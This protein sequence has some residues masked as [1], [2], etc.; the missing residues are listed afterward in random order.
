[1]GNVCSPTA[2]PAGISLRS[3]ERQLSWVAGG[4]DSGSRSNSLGSSSHVNLYE[5]AEAGD[6][7]I[8]YTPST[9]DYFN[10][11][12]MCQ[13]MPSKVVET[14][15]IPEKPFKCVVAVV[16]HG[17]RLDQVDPAAW[18]RSD[19]G[20]AYPFDCPLTSKGRKAARRT[21]EEIQNSALEFA[22]VVSS[23]Y[24]RC[25]QTAA[26]ICQILGLQ[27]CID[28]EL[29][30]IYGPRTHGQW[31]EPPPRRTLEEISSLVKLHGDSLIDSPLFVGNEEKE[32]FGSHSEWP[33]TLEDA[34][35]RLVSRVEQY[36][37][38]SLQLRK[39]FLLV[40]H[41]DC[42]AAS[43]GLLL[44]SQQ[45][46]RRVVTKIDY[47]AYTLAERM[48]EPEDDLAVPLGLADEDAN[49]KLT[50]GNCQVS[51]LDESAGGPWKGPFDPY[52][53]PE[54][55]E[56]LECYQEL[57]QRLKLEEDEAEDAEGGEERHRRL[58][59]K[60]STTVLSCALH[61]QK[62]VNLMKEMG[63]FGTQY[64]ELV[65]EPKADAGWK[66]SSAQDIAQLFM[67]KSS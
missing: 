24:V 20:R 49:W 5:A 40:T 29:G 16:R 47:C 7:P 28:A 63:P 1:M 21:A 13:T 67:G 41:G 26:E 22:L 11:L 64:G 53:L 17:D 57:Q 2:V 23:P 39:N 65:P 38:R 6:T 54:E 37:A 46:C 51:D 52:P 44:S 10:I 60:T 58:M 8:M 34:R 61:R 32:F 50:F 43:L 56:R 14:E 42:V 30:E 19:L 18:F 15:P 25:V 4:K 33:E 36:Q 31:E 45:G 48:V 62:S 3:H 27:L 9:V 55:A 35:L 66:I 12:A 59:R